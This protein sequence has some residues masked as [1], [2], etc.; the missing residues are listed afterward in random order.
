[1][2]IFEP[3][4]RYVRFAAIVTAVDRRGRGVACL[5]PAEIPARE[6]LGLHRRRDGQRLDHMAAHYLDDPAG[7]RRIADHN[8]AMTAEAAIDTPLVGIPVKG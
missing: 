6:R 3:K 8:D 5:T 2:S 4:S 7:Y 1:M